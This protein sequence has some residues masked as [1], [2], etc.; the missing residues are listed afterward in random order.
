MEKR[1]DFGHLYGYL[2]DIPLDCKA[3]DCDVCAD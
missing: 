1:S 2:S 3:A